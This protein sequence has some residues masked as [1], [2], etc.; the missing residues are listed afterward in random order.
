MNIQP[1]KMSNQT[2]YINSNNKQNVAFG[3]YSSSITEEGIKKVLN[4]I[5]GKTS[6]LNE[7]CINFLSSNILK[8]L[9]KIQKKYSKDK[10][11]DVHTFIDPLDNY[12]NIWAQVGTSKE[13]KSAQP[14]NGRG[15]GNVQLFHEFI[16]S[17]KGKIK[18]RVDVYADTLRQ[19]YKHLVK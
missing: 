11:V 1:I 10:V 3:H 13:V 15:Q 5:S 4:T 17:F 16:V 18:E 19:E 14:L 8:T 2:N 12:I 7:D 6:M 9:S